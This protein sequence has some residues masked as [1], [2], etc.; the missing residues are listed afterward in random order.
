MHAS[1]RYLRRW[2]RHRPAQHVEADVAAPVA[3]SEVVRRLKADDIPPRLE[4][5]QA[6]APGA[7]ALG[8]S[9]SELA[10]R[11]GA[12]D[13]LRQ[14]G[15]HAA[16][17][18][19]RSGHEVWIYDNLSTGHS[20]AALSRRLIVGDLHDTD[21]LR[22]V[23][24]ARNI[25]A[26]MHFAASSLVGESVAHPAKYYRNNLVGALSLLEAMRVE[27]SKLPVRNFRG[28]FS[29]RGLPPGTTLPARQKS[30]GGGSA[31]GRGMGRGRGR[32]AAAATARASPKEVTEP[33]IAAALDDFVQATPL[34][35][36]SGLAFDVKICLISFSV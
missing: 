2:E 19:D 22:Y 30:M 29:S 31:R 8:R 12:S 16:R 28:G 15:A 35:A 21:L 9:G 14:A 33:N 32:G 20:A 18:L 36:L 11:L 17:L 34:E 24:R 25:D 7:A 3:G 13:L 6:L 1:C 23:L 10:R 5:D 27:E 26:V 4:D